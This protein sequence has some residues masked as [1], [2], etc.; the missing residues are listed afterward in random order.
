M[1]PHSRSRLYGE[2]K[3]L[4]SLTRTE[5]RFP[6]FQPLAESLYRLRF[7]GERKNLLFMQ[8]LFA[9]FLWKMVIN[10]RRLDGCVQQHLE[11][12]SSYSGNTRPLELRRRL[13]TFP[14]RLFLS[15]AL[16]FYLLRAL[17]VVI[18]IV[19]LISHSVGMCK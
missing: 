11:V 4:L 16:H 6:I 13:P 12:V 5:P 3:R 14:N 10:C 2:D 15:M 7:K 17:A 9:V 19:V 1:P 18:C 8:Q